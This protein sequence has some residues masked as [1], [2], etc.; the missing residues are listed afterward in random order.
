MKRLGIAGPVGAAIHWDHDS[1]NRINCILQ[2]FA[3][4][5]SQGCI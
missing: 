3:R 5:D 4:G 2:S 1:Y